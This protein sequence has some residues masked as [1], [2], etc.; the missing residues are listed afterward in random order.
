[1]RAAFQIFRTSAELTRKQT[2]KN[3]M[4]S[5]RIS[6]MSETETMGMPAMAAGGRARTTIPPS[7]TALDCFLMGSSPSTRRPAARVKLPSLPIFRQLSW[8]IWKESSVAV[9]WPGRT[10]V[11]ASRQDFGYDLGLGCQCHRP[12][13]LIGE[14]R[15]GV[16][17]EQMVDCREDVLG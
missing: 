8:D 11:F 15:G 5:S 13:L 4:V 12:A 9:G 2:R 10:L 17:A 1:M 7:A 6:A 3:E 14:D 16:D